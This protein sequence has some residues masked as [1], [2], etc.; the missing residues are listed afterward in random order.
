MR[1]RTATRRVDRDQL[2]ELVD[3]I[4][5]QLAQGR[6]EQAV[7]RDLLGL[8]FR[9]AAA[10]SLVSRVARGPA[11]RPGESARARRLITDA[12]LLAAGV[13]VVL[14]C[15]SAKEHGAP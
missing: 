7:A 1:K 14:A 3:A 10:Q 2:H 5:N 9:P 15:V 4:A 12:L 13:G 8:G 11:G 6:C